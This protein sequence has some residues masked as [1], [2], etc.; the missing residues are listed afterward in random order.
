MTREEEYWERVEQENAQ[1]EVDQRRRD[2]EI[3]YGGREALD[4]EIELAEFAT[5]RERSAHRQVA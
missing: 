2:R 1:D 5:A 4:L 3:E